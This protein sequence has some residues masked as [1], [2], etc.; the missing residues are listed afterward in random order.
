MLT[1][2]GLSNAANEAMWLVEAG[3]GISRV[4]VYTDQETPVPYEGWTLTLDGLRRRT[5]QEPLQY[6][7]GTQ[8]FRGLSLMVAEGVFI[9]R[10]ETELL[11]DEVIAQRDCVEGGFIADI[12][13]GSGC[14]AIAL[15][16]EIS[17]A[18]VYA[19]ER[20]PTAMAMAKHNAVRHMVMDR[21]TFLD[22]DMVGPLYSLGMEECFSCIVSNPPYI[23]SDQ[24]VSLPSTVRDFEP[25]MAL[26]GGIEGLDFYL[27]LLQDVPGLLKPGGKLVLEMGA[28]QADRVCHEAERRGRFTVHRIRDD[29]AGIAR[30]VSLERIH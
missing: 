2:A 8:E 25:D 15:A 24:L 11:V 9:P 4:A 22:G 13:T 1:Q 14:L 17:E 21:I 30:V 16:V 10:P 29:G 26:D 7:L 23:P 20:S 12:G 3:F 5:A 19:V 18:M 6:I 27:R 28:G